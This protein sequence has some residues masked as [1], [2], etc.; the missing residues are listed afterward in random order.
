MVFTLDADLEEPPEILEDFFKFL[1]SNE[2][3]NIVGAIQPTRKGK[4]FEV[5]LGKI[6][7][8]IGRH[9]FGYS[10]KANQLALFLM[11]S[12]V[13]KKLIALPNADL[14]LIGAINS[15]GF[16]PHFFTVKKLS[17]SATSYTFFA[18]LRLAG[19]LLLSHITKPIQ[20]LTLF[21]ITLGFVSLGLILWLISRY[22][23]GYDTLAGWSST[24]IVLV[25][26]GSFISVLQTFTLL[27]LGEI[28]NQQRGLKAV[29]EDQLVN[30]DE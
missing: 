6:F 2:Q 10:P 30:F 28:L 22:L 11:K 9:I 26:W 27:I 14:T 29:I 5:L 23:M 4:F 17:S 21:S 8:V 19:R 18:K 15:L 12:E 13:V 1:N 7:Y 24:I 25:F 20:I 3:A 16:Q